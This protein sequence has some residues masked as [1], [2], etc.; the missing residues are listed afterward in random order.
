MAYCT[1]TEV[2]LEIGTSHGTV[3][4]TDIT[5]MITQSDKEIA[6]ILRRKGLTAPTGANDDLNIASIQLTIAKVKRR[7][8]HELSRPGS[9]NLG[10]DISFSTQPE[11]EAVAAEAKAAD[12]IAAY[13]ASVNGSGIR[14]SRVRT[15]R[16]R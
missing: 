2:E 12:A 10:G 11:T 14:A 6:G 15:T 9:L 5:N 1:Y 4:T 3:T 13:I 16:C 8:S 7:Q